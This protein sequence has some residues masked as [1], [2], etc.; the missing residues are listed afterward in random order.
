MGSLIANSNLIKKVYF[1]ARDPRCLHRSSRCSSPSASRWRCSV[2]CSCSSGTW[3]CHGSRWSILIML[4]EAV[5]VAGI[6][7]V[8]SVID[9][10]FRDT[11]HFMGDRLAGALLL[12]AD[13]LSD[14]LC[15]E[16]R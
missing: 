10:Y 8:L 14:Q 3:S 11:E 15:A 2:S 16:D 6:G 1:P 4:I 9:V 12:C 5:F 13:R 7:L